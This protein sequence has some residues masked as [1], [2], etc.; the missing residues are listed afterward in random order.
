MVGRM[1]LWECESG[2][3]RSY[4]G[5]MERVGANFDPLVLKALREGIT[6]ILLP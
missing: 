4:R 3:P 2:L 5:A 1:K 6:S